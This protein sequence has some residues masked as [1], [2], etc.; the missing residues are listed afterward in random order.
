VKAAAVAPEPPLSRAFV[1]AWGI[2]VA[3]APRTLARELVALR[4][5]AGK[6]PAIL[7]RLLRRLGLVRRARMRHAGAAQPS[8]SD[9]S[10]A[11]P[12]AAVVSMESVRS[13]AKR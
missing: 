3:L 12:P 2:G 10:V 9:S 13:V 8:P 11:L 7:D 6:R 1:A 5:V 4:F